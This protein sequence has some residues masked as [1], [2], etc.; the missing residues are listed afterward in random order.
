MDVSKVV[1]YRALE[2]RAMDLERIARSAFDEEIVAE[3]LSEALA[4]R[5][6][7]LQIVRGED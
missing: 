6:R 1:R 7:M 4:V 3:N 2:E 5:A